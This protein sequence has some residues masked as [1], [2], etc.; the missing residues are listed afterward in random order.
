[1]QSLYYDIAVIIVSGKRTS[2]PISYTQYQ[3]YYL[4][5]K[6]YTAFISA[7]IIIKHPPHSVRKTFFH[8][9]VDNTLKLLL[10]QI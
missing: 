9:C 5:S 7:I 2:F 6:V 10:D 4:K 8:Y 1:M 3:K